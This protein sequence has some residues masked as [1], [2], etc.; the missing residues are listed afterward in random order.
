MGATETRLALLKAE[1]PVV[2]YEANMADEKELDKNS[3][4]SRI[5]SFMESLGI[6][7]LES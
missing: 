4:L 5:D 2:T 6:E 1:Y 7:K 3:V